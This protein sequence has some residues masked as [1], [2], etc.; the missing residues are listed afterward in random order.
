MACACIFMA[1]DKEGVESQLKTG[2][3]VQEGRSSALSSTQQN[4]VVSFDEFDHNCKHF[5]IIS[6]RYPDLIKRNVFLIVCKIL[7]K[8]IPVNPFIILAQ[9][10]VFKL[11]R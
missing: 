9:V 11:S 4:R 3:L 6:S 7:A 1:I 2:Y 8:A 5:C 10:D